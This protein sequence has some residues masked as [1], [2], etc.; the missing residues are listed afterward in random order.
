LDDEGLVLLLV[1]F[2]GRDEGFEG[3]SCWLWQLNPFL[4]FFLFC[5]SEEGRECLEVSS[6]QLIFHMSECL[7]V[8]KKYMVMFGTRIKRSGWKC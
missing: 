4:S 6:L 1:G 8:N 5:E 2:G 3:D 7:F